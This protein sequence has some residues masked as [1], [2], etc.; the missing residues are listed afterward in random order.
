MSWFH[1]I[2]NSGILLHTLQT[3]ERELKLTHHQ[4]RIQSIVE[5]ING[6]CEY[7]FSLND[8]NKILIDNNVWEY[9]RTIL[10]Q[11]HEKISL[12]LSH[13]ESQPS[14]TDKIKNIELLLFQITK[15]KNR[16]FYIIYNQNQN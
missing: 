14:L 6:C 13:S 4:P 1:H 7:C 5:W 2:N 9:L 10:L 3:L 16:N 12:E 11:L 8:K 15:E